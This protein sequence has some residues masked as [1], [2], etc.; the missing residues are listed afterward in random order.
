MWTAV[1]GIFGNVV[2]GVLKHLPTLAAY[3][4]GR[5][6]EKAKQQAR[7]LR[8]KEKQERIRKRNEKRTTDELLKR[9]K[10]YQRDE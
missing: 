4:S 3:F 8:K 2:G 1:I 6:A 7:V 5:K 9:A 10:K